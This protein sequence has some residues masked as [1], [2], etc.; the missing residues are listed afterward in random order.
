MKPASTAIFGG[1]CLRSGLLWALESPP[2]DP[3][4]FSAFQNIGEARGAKITDNWGNK[5]ENSLRSI[6][7]SWMPQTAAT[8]EEREKV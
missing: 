5:P 1:G 2:G 6:F 4:G 7:R 3:R 8:V